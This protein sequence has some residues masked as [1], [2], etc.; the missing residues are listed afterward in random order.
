MI[1]E[2]PVVVLQL[3]ENLVAGHAQI[4]F[5]EIEALLKADR[6]RV[7]FDFSAVSRIDRS[8]VGGDN[9]CK[10]PTWRHW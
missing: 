6:P 10:L 7:V 1:T 9:G 4:F 8:G 2:R 3:P 5:R